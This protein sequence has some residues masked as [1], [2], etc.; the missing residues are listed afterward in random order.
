MHAGGR[1]DAE[2]KLARVEAELA[3]LDKVHDSVARRSKRLTNVLLVGGFMVLF[4]QWAAFCYLT[5]CERWGAANGCWADNLRPVSLT[6]V[7]ALIQ[8]GCVC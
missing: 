6:T 3:E 8:C 2:S 7:V 5:W 4:T 1:E